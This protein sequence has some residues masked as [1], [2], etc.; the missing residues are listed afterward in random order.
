MPSTQRNPNIPVRHRKEREPTFLRFFRRL[1]VLFWPARLVVEEACFL[2]SPFANGGPGRW[3]RRRERQR[4]IVTPAA[5]AVHRLH[6]FIDHQGWQAL[7]SA[8]TA[9]PGDQ[10]HNFSTAFVR[11]RQLHLLFERF[12]PEKGPHVGPNLGRSPHQTRSK[13]AAILLQPYPHRLHRLKGRQA[14]AAYLASRGAPPPR[15]P[16]DRAGH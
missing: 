12:L 11:N 16:R 6:E 15:A 1:I 8:R 13:P 10:T 14:S 5:F 3:L 9:L 7:A 2:L 4:I